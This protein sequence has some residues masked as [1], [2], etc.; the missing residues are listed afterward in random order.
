MR[1]IL[2]R[3]KRAVLAGRLVFTDKATE[4]IERD[5]LSELDVAEALIGAPAISKT[6]R[7]THPSR[8]GATEY[9]FVI[10]GITLDGILVY[11]KGR[12]ARESG[13]DHFY[14]LVSSKRG[15]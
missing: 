3:I 2:R 4:E 7:S 10:H 8:R 6:L 13:E 5:H 15:Q 14:V 1:D 11:T 9:L 12:L